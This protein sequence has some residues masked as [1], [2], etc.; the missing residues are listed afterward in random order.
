[1]VKE[2]GYYDMFNVADLN[3]V[4]LLAMHHTQNSE[5]ANV[6]AGIVADLKTPKSLK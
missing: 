4:S 6:G 5:F 2:I 3:E 1:M